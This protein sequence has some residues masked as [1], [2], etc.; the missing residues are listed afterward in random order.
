MRVDWVA[1]RDSSRLENESTRGTQTCSSW[2]VLGSRVSHSSLKWT[3]PEGVSFKVNHWETTDQKPSVKPIEPA[4]TKNT[5]FLFTYIV[6]N[7][8]LLHNSQIQSSPMWG[9]K[10]KNY[11]TRKFD[12]DVGQ[13]IITLRVDAWEY[14][15][16][17]K[18]CVL[19]ELPMKNDRWK[20]M[21]HKEHELVSTCPGNHPGR[22]L[23]HRPP[24]P[25]L[26][27]ALHGQ[28]PDVPD[29]HTHT[30]TWRLTWDLYGS[31]LWPCVTMNENRHY[32]Q[33]KSRVTQIQDRREV[34]MH[35]CTTW[36]RKRFPILLPH[37]SL[38]TWESQCCQCVWR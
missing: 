5:F 14:M 33:C 29:T 20:A 9:H 15:F 4:T 19:Y 31:R 7:H 22:G 34:K 1:H 2:S 36:T 16:K 24:P 26:D 6:D 27:Q 17:W 35:T 10:R 37:T 21:T 28:W 12:E 30:R 8:R 23:C 18:G 25:T 13:R 3:R 32:Q 11:M 38:P